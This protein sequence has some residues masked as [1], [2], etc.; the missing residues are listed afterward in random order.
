MA[1]IA[2][3]TAISK[4]A[5]VLAICFLTTA[6]IEAKKNGSAIVDFKPTVF[7]AKADSKFFYSIGKDLKFSDHI[8]ADAPTLLSGNFLGE[9]VSPDGRSVALTLNGELLIVR[10]GAPVLHVV[11]VRSISPHHKSMGTSFFRDENYQWS[12]DSKSLYLIKDAY[13]ASKGWQLFSR[14]GELWRYKLETGS[15]ELV[16]KPFPAFKYFWANSVLYYSIPDEQGN[17]HLMAFDGTSSHEE[18]APDDS[19]GQTKSASI[20]SAFYSFNFSDYRHALESYLGLEDD[21]KTVPGIERISYRGK[22]L[23]ELT[24][25]KGWDGYYF[26]FDIF[27][28]SFPP[29]QRFLVLNTPY[30]DNYSGTQLMIDVSTGSMMTLP[31]DTR[32]FVPFNTE[33]YP[34]YSITRDGIGVK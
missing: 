30:C 22:K 12:R 24:Q 27:G 28:S 5:L 14:N 34:H 13:Y 3:K 19:R 11:P 1:K 23:L 26:C 7:D 15:L 6:K 20:P 31:K 29:G 2:S 4:T 17:L 21:W 9:L 33:N 18:S 10:D 25:G 8:D 16:L 32:V